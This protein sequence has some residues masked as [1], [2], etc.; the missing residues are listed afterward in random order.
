MKVVV[1]QDACEG[2]ARCV[3]AAPTVFALDEDERSYALIERPGADLRA[4]VKLAVRRCPRQA[5]KLV[6]DDPP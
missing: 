6:E 2:Y 4:Q 5:I 3:A 1:D